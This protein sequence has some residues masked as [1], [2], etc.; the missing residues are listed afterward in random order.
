MS[1]TYRRYQEARDTAWRALLQ[2]R[3]KRLPIDVEALAG[4]VGMQ[5]NPFPEE[6]AQPKLYALVRRAGNDKC[7]SLRIRGAWHVFLRE[8]RLGDAERRYAVA[9]ELGHL[10]LGHETYALSPGVRAFRGR[11]N[12]GDL[13]DDPEDLADYAADIFAI[14]LLAPA[15][16]LHDMRIDTAGGIMRQCGMP[17]RAAALRAERM[18]LLNARDAFFSHPLERQVRDAFLPFLREYNTR[19]RQ[20]AGAPELPAAPSAGRPAVLIAPARRQEEAAEETHNEPPAPPPADPA[21]AGDEKPRRRPILWLAVIGAAL[22]GAAL[23]L[24]LRR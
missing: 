7:V 17:P 18:Q 16:L 20:A 14:R 19:L 9:H 15:C 13:L 24:L 2:A 21:P 6:K 8:D 5:V 11:E 1:S 22:L 10:L 12:D 3:D 23:F 4:A